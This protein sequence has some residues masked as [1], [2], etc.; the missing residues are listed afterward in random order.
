MVLIFIFWFFFQGLIHIHPK[1]C[2]QE[3]PV[4]PVHHLS[5][6]PFLLAPVLLEFPRETQLSLRVSLLILSHDRDVQD[7]HPRAPALPH[8]HHLVLACAL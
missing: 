7:T 1:W 6:L 2:A 5:I 8:T 3:V 4:L